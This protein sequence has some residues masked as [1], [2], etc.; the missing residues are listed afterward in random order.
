MATSAIEKIVIHCT[1]T[2]PKASITAKTI[3]AWHQA[4]NFEPRKQAPNG[5][6]YIGYNY[7]GLVD[8]K[9][10][11]GRDEG[12]KLQHAVGFQNNSI[13]YCMVGGVDVASKAAINF[14]DLQ[15]K[16]LRKFCDWMMLKY[17]NAEIMGHRDLPNVAKDCPC[18]DV[19]HWLETGIAINARKIA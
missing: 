15:W 14:T 6:F 8:G 13:A 11:I 16:T 12:E 3:D 4:R 17:P 1:A 7:V 2:L 10:E 18:F 9:V 19:R 5:L